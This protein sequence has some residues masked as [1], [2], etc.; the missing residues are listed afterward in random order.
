MVYSIQ[1]QSD[2]LAPVLGQKQAVPVPSR[3]QT[4]VFLALLLLTSVVSLWDYQSFQLGTWHD[5]ANYVIL[6]RSLLTAD[7]YGQINVPGIPTDARYPFGYP[8]ILAPLMALFPDNLDVLKALSLLTTL[9]N[10][11]MIFWGWKW[12]S[13]RSH[14]WAVAVTGFYLLTPLTIE[15]TRMV[16]AEP[17]F[18]SFCLIA[19]LTTAWLSRRS[20][21]EG[22]REWLWLLVLGVSLVF[23]AFTRTIGLIPVA[24]VFFYLLWQRGWRFWKQL[25]ALGL[26]MAGLVTAV[27][28]LTPVQITS[29]LF[30]G[31][32]LQG[33]QASFL[34]GFRS[35]LGQAP[36][37]SIS[38]RYIQE[39]AQTDGQTAELDRHTFFSDFI[40][41]ALY[42]LGKDFRLALIQF[43]GGDREE[44]LAKRIGLPWLTPA[45]GYAVSILIALGF[46]WDAFRVRQVS[47]FT[48][49]AFLYATALFLWV[50]DG[51]R[52][53]YPVLPQLFYGF[54]VGMETAMLPV[55]FLLRRFR[56]AR[57][58][59][60][61]WMV[62]AIL[63]TAG[64]LYK[65]LTMRGSRAHVG[66]LQARVVWIRDHADPEAVV[67]TE[68][69]LVMYLYSQRYTV[70]FSE[71]L[72]S[73]VSLS[74]FIRQNNVNYILVA[75]QRI[76]QDE[77]YH[78]VYSR[79]IQS[80]LPLLDELTATGQ[81][82]LVHTADEHLVKVF[83]VQP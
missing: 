72:V 49:F 60:V 36:P 32:Y 76:W 26:I 19:M 27:V 17:V 68:D 47:I 5:D 64:H 44:E 28:A 33:V 52:L 4:A 7:K 65:D 83:Q 50:W 8:L 16:M 79:E 22:G 69:P 59:L 82:T 39:E 73:A 46:F 23:V 57:V 70:R 61:G 37:E 1:G 3:W 13:A 51:P 81:L 34:N 25:L 58:I 62:V 77:G 43:G 35:L 55:V 12:F 40:G 71:E 2:R 18:M 56:P 80:L 53:L 63:I 9:A 41:G 21:D 54:L 38:E 6:A 78:P 42:H 24:G 29:G 30:P 11:A 31:R 66:D 20:A 75:S 14:W 74:E 15:H 67:L 48:F 10:G 45:V